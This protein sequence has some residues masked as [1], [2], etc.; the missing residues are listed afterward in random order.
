VLTDLF[1]EFMGNM[2]KQVLQVE[3]TRTHTWI[4]R[5]RKEGRLLRCY[6]QNIDGLEHRLMQDDASPSVTDDQDACDELQHEQIIQLHGSLHR[7]RCTLCTYT[8]EYDYSHLDGF[9]SSEPPDC[10][11][12]TTDSQAREKLQ[13]RARP[14]GTLRPAVVLYNEPHPQGDEISRQ[15]M[16]DAKMGD[17][18]IVMGTSLRVHGCKRLVKELARGVHKRGGEVVF[19]NMDP[20]SWREWGPVLDWWVEG[21]SDAWVDDV[22]TRVEQGLTKDVP[23]TCPDMSLT[24]VEKLHRPKHLIL[25]GPLPVPSTPTK[26]T[27]QTRIKVPI[28]KKATVTSGNKRK[29]KAKRVY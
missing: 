15:M 27:K 13:K 14:I 25:G 20:V 6:T 23:S 3:P 5:V 10:P 2:T 4:E 19:V 29:R 21:A 26:I 16:R 22:L 24:V 18:L 28:V 9:I 17:C 7:V 12:C 11:K 1:Y 8:L